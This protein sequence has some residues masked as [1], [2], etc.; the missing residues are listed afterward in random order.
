MTPPDGESPPP[1]GSTVDKTPLRKVLRERRARYL[2]AMPPSVR[3]I[4]F[5]VL[6]SPVIRR[7]P[8]DATIALYYA[9]GDE[10]PTANIAGQLED[11]GYRLALPR[12]AP[13]TG[14]MH[15]AEWD[16]EQILVP[17]AFRTLQPGADAAEVKPDVI[18]APLVGYDDALNRLG[19]GG[20]YY[21][22]AF[23]A[24]PD[25]LRIGLGWSAQQVERVPVEPH[26]LPLHMVVT[27]AA[28]LEREDS[29]R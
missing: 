1:S 13:K 2:A 16:V 26:D 21:D 11:L 22:R 19:Q 25:A 8:T 20:G 3:G 6:P 17:G 4:A 12:M 27:E 10:A 23:A 5:R 15:F 29:G 28:I 9:T 7:L 14:A 24:Y 18:I